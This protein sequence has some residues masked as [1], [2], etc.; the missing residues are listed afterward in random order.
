MKNTDYIWDQ[1]SKP[2][3]SKMGRYKTKIE[4]EFIENSL[5]G[6]SLSSKILDIGGGSGR[7][8]KKLKEKGFV[9]EIID[10]N[11]I[12]IK[13]AQENSLEAKC[14]NFF[15]FY[16]EQKFDAI[17]A[18]EV[19]TYIE[20][21]SL[22]CDKVTSLMKTGGVFIFTAANPISWRYLFRKLLQRKSK[23]HEQPLQSYFDQLGNDYEIIEIVGFMWQPF[24]LTSNNF[25][26]PFFAQVV[27]L[28]FHKLLKQSPWWLFAC[29]KK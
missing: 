8:S 7:F 24:T 12:A 21:K 20:N 25:M 1:E 23:F 28:F 19:L 22:F 4:Y 9:P 11:E 26:I 17:L 29:L 6:F 14:V 18:I 16:S 27:K 2:Y 13:I 10:T 15:E 5:K 3:S